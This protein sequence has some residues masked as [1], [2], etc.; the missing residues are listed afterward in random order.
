MNGACWVCFLLPAFTHQGHECSDLL[1]PCGGMHVCTDKTLVY[2]LIQKNFQEM[3]WEPML[4]PKG[5][6]ISSGGSEDDQTHNAAPRRTAS[7]THHQLSYSGLIH[8][9]KLPPYILPHDTLFT[10]SLTDYPPHFI[11]LKT[12][13]FTISMMYFFSAIPLRKWY[14]ADY[15]L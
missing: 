14:T 11:H 6:I 7:P 12:I 13:N 10:T 5:K 1:S 2:A 9:S 4:T 8:L 3:E 15:K